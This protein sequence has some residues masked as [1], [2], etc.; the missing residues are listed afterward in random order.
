MPV[1]KKVDRRR[2]IDSGLAKWLCGL[3]T[4]WPLCGRDRTEDV[5]R[6][7]WF[8][9]REWALAE[10]KRLGLPTPPQE[11]KYASSTQD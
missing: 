2:R 8:E 5:L 9:H 7:T 1:R 10:A 4:L 3:P 6:A 11:S